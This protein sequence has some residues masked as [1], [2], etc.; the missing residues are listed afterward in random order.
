MADTDKKASGMLPDPIFVDAYVISWGKGKIARSFTSMAKFCV[1][2]YGAF[3]FHD[4]WMK[5]MKK[6]GC[7]INFWK[8]N[9][10]DRDIK[11]QSFYKK[12]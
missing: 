7:T 1:N 3:K 4:S 10:V 5:Y 9:D 11:N 12:L 2:Y 6:G 8:F